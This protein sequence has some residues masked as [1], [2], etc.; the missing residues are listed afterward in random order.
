MRIITITARKGGV[1]KTTVTVNLAYELASKGR[2]VLVIDLDQQSDTSKFLRWG[3]TEY[4][5]GD[6]LL[7]KRFDVTK[8][9]YPAKI[10]GEEQENLHIITGRPNDVMVKL[11]KEVFT[12]HSSEERLN[13]QLKKLDGLYDFVLI[14]TP[15]TANTLSMNAVKASTEFIFPANLSELSLDGIDSILDHIQ[16][17]NDL[18]MDEINFMIVPSGVPKV[19]KKTVEY[20]MNYLE[21]K[22]SGHITDTTIWQ[23]TSIFSEAE[24]RH[25]PVSLVKRSDISA[26][27]FR[28]L[29]QEIINNAI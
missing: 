18:E 13:H 27:H 23:K 16:D 7:N 9:I 26:L 1:T 22:Y 5:V 8:A 24:R 10:K 15:P 19:A 17:L 2:K 28:E 20:G 29:A 11:D 14:D 3:E 12:L 25:L 21:T 4:Y 6:I